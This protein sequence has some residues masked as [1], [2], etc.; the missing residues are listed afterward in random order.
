ME[1]KEEWK[2]IPGSNEVYVSNMGRFKK[3]SGEILEPKDDGQGYLRI[4]VGNSLRDRCHRF[5]AEAFVPNPDNKPQVDHINGDKKDNRAENLRWVT[6]CENTKYAGEMGLIQNFGKSK[7]IVGISTDHS[8]IMFFS[9]QKQ[10]GLILD[11]NDKDINKALR[12]HR[13]TSH[14]YYWK[15]LDDVNVKNYSDSF[16]NVKEKIYEKREQEHG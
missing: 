7:E 3:Y 9:S 6:S 5:V 2:Y 14:G 8:S 4:G 1:V 11:I 12:E 15:Y 16:I 10:A 13:Q